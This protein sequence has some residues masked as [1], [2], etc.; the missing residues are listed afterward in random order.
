MPPGQAGAGFSL[1]ELEK[2]DAKKANVVDDRD[3]EITVALICKSAEELGQ[4]GLGGDDNGAGLQGL[5]DLK[6]RN[7]RIRKIDHFQMVRA[8]SCVVTPTCISLLAARGQALLATLGPCPLLQV[9]PFPRPSNL[10]LFLPPSL[11]ASV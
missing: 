10:L 11:P 9:T 2:A 7:K 5:Y 1:R 3:Q 4:A 6:L 8:P